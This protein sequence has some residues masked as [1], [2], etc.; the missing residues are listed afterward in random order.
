MGLAIVPM[1]LLGLILSWRS[2]TTQQR[3]ALYVQHEMTQRV[4]AHVETFFEKLENELK[5]ISQ[6][7]GLTTLD[8]GEQNSILSELLMYQRFFEE[9]ILLDNQGREQTHVARSRLVTPATDDH[10]ELHAVFPPSM[11][12]QIGYS[13]VWFEKTQGEPF[14]TMAVPLVDVRSGLPH[15]TLIA[16]VRIKTIWHLIADMRVNPGQDVYIVDAQH[17]VV[18]HRNP[19]VVLRGTKF[20]VPAREGE[21]LGLHGSQV[22]LTLQTLHLGDQAFTI[23]VEQTWSEAMALAISAIYITLTLTVMM[24][25]IS[26]TLG[27]LSVRKIV[28]PIQTMATAAQAISMGDLSQHIPTRRDDEL[29]VLAETFNSMTAQLRGLISGLEQRVAER[30]ASLQTANAHLQREI[31]ERRQT[32][33]DLQQAKDHAEAANRAKA[34][35]L[36]TMSHEIRTPMNGVLGMTKLL[37]DTALTAT[38]NEYAEMI[39]R[40]AEALLSIINDILDFSKIEA[41]KLDLEMIDFNLRDTV[42][43]VLELLAGQAYSKNLEL[44]CR[45]TDEVPTW[46][47]GDPGR[48]RQIVTNLVGNALK[49]TE[50]GEVVVNI[51]LMEMSKD[52]TL[53][54]FEVIDTGIG[55]APEVQ[56]HL[57]DAFSQANSSTT[58]KYGGTGLG[59]TISQ[60]LVTM[61]GG[62]I[63]IESTPGQGSTFWFMVP[64]KLGSACRQTECVAIPALQGIRVMCI[65]GHT[66]SRTILETQLSTW[67]MQVSGIANGAMALEQLCT[68]QAQGQPYTLAI[69]DDQLPDID[70]VALVQAIK[71]DPDLASIRLMLLS[72]LNRYASNDTAQQAAIAAIVAK[73]VR[74]SHLYHGLL[75]TLGIASEAPSTVAGRNH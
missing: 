6:V 47:N 72:A 37:L 33:I 56:H 11:D 64:F 8:R 58:R 36:A 27:F 71:A 46:V 42:E 15:G 52:T 13:S 57:F 43:D 38:Q 74:Q 69:L 3:Q 2:Y 48:L 26:S 20:D 67:G 54:R 70:S 34:D 31:A 60:R 7:Q 59:L 5:V 49:F 25:G 53:I 16:V 18:A 63:G 41:D 32:E 14:I 50:Q 40:S 55:I 45:L 9:L 61:M 1:I 17:T 4:S 22:I 75:S 12:N 35:F 19:S 51:D 24:L 44:A 10:A 30:T 73:P 62:V 23:V 21:W 29:G 66:T 28:Q 39:R 65:D 68:A